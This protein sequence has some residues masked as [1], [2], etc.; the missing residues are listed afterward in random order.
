MSHAIGHLI[1]GG[2]GGGGAAPV[3][4]A[5]I[6]KPGPDRGKQRADMMSEMK[7]AQ[8]A[9]ADADGAVLSDNDADLLGKHGA[10]TPGRKSAS[11]RLLG[12]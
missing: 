12:G 7:S 6:D 1:G 3:A 10:V 5:P 8:R 11:A 4:A 2:G 9:T